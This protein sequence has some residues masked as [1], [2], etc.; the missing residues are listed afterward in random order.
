MVE[1]MSRSKTLT[2]SDTIQQVKDLL[3]QNSHSL[4]MAATQDARLHDSDPFFVDGLGTLYASDPD[5]RERVAD[6]FG[7]GVSRCVIFYFSYTIVD[8]TI[9]SCIQHFWFRKDSTPG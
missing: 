2:L 5:T 9:K 4:K 7:S 1:V 6:L 8:F 3:A